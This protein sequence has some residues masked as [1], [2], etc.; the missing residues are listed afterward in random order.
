MTDA[1]RS[2]D[3]IIVNAAIH[4]MDASAPRAGALAAAGG[5]ILALGDDRAMRSIAGPGARTIDAG[6]RLVLPGFQD[7]HIH[8]QDSGTRFARSANL[9]SARSIA[10]LQRLIGEFTASRPGDPWI[11]GAGWYSGVFGEHN[12]NRAVLDEIVADRPVYLHASD[13]HSAV[14]NSAAC[15][16]LGLDARTKDPPNGHFVRDARGTPTGLV[17]ED[18]IDWVRERMPAPTGPEFAEGVRYG[19][20]ECN[21]HGITGVVDAHVEERH[22]LVYKSL[23]DDGGLSV[24]IAATAKIYPEETVANALA[25]LVA[26]RDRFRSPM[27]YVHSA[28]F[29]LDGVFENRTA[30]MIEPYCDAAGGNAPLMFEER[31][32]HALFIAFDKARFQIHVHVIGDKAVRAALDGLEAAR[33][34]N[35]RWPSLHQLAHVQVVDPVDIPRFRELGVVANIQPLWARLEP[36]VTEVAV[37]MAGNKRSRWIYPFRSL[38]ESGAVL[39]VSSDWGVS[40][41]NPF[42]IMHTAVTRRPGYRSSNAPAFN[43]E[44]CLDV[45]T[46]VRGYTVDAAAS[47]WRSSDTGSLAPG[48]LADIIVLDRDVFSIPPDSI[49]DT[50]VLLTLLAGQEVHRASEFAG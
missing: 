17:H 38:Q 15:R 33:R 4:T 45:A 11:N 9:E 27:L 32:L 42:A 2:A 37:P 31:H 25:R 22:M 30:A 41:L 40:T 8:L 36:S 47:A 49:Q 14:L 26:L 19:Q 34:T 1:N 20:K 29:F 12:L 21:R 24:R 5:R 6:G 16:L 13:G 48:K 3:L 44:E 35:G 50:R 7:T 43:P 39:A 23:E 46:V 10:E 18:A 28:K